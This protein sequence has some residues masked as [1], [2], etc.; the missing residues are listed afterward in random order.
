[1]LFSV[2]QFWKQAT[3]KNWKS[4]TEINYIGCFV[5]YSYQP[6]YKNAIIVSAVDFGKIVLS[7]APFVKVVHVSTTT[8]DSDHVHYMKIGIYYYKIENF[9]MDNFL[10]LLAK[11]STEITELN[12]SYSP[13][14][15]LVRPLFGTNK[16]TKFKIC[17]CKY[18]W[19]RDIPT[20]GIE[21]LTLLFHNA[22]ADSVSYQGVGIICNFKIFFMLKKFVIDTFLHYFQNENQHFVT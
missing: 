7:V 15:D 17:D 12:F 3:L 20:H 19:Y 8:E 11:K 18:S 16:I 13:A 5:E 2:C 6:L 4:I 14:T 1:M 9:K 21:E 22:I 10:K